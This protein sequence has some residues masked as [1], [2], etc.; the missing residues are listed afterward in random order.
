M[1]N[2]LGHAATR[3]EFQELA[4]RRL[5]DAKVSLD[6]G[7]W[8]AAYYL[9]GYAV[10]CGLKASI[11]RRRMKGGLFPDRDF[12]TSVYTHNLDALVRLANLT[13]A[14][15]NWTRAHRAF[16]ERWGVVAR[17]K[18]ESRYA[19]SISESEARALYEAL[20]APKL[21]VLTWLKK[22]W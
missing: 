18:E 22:H 20:T 8:A 15:D 21:G 11:C 2:A 9:C 3:L 5:A 7:R 1:P 17:W 4:L 19:V 10:E 14:R 6:A 16:G 13:V 12:A